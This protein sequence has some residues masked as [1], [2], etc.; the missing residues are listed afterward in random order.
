[1]T[2]LAAFV[3]AY[4]VPA[5]D[6]GRQPAMFLRTMGG[7]HF[8]HHGFGEEGPPPFDES[9][10]ALLRNQGLI[11]IEYHQNSQSISPS[12]RGQEVAAEW[13]RVQAAEAVA[14]TAGVAAA[15]EALA[16]AESPT[17]WVGVRPVL[18]ALRRYWV[19]G[20]LPADG[21]ILR[22]IVS[23]IPAESQELFVATINM[24]V[25]SEYLRSMGALTFAD[26]PAAVALTDR[27]RTQLDGWPGASPEDLVE[28]LV[29]VISEQARQEPNS[30]KRR[31]LQAI[32]EAFRELGIQTAS[33]IVSK[34]IMGR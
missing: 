34:A 19:D 14:D 8:Q 5:G 24:L 12:A 7:L 26:M 18:A 9:V 16:E 2:F 3:Q 4:D 17:A 32:V 21:I 30:T 29:A 25:E 22:P 1:M 6:R 27:A 15:V 13:E 20:G 33:E 31:R 10:L 11:E 23:G 28:N